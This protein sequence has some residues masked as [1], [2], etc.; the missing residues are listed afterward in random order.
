MNWI[1][2][3]ID[4]INSKYLYKF[5]SEENLK[6]FLDTGNIWFSRSDKF[7]DRMEC[8]MIKDLIKSPPD[9]K[10]IEARK[11]RH[12]ISCFHEGNIETLAFWDTYAK[13]DKDRRKYALRFNREDLIK[14]LILNKQAL[15][16]LSSISRLVH[17]RVRYL[18]LIGASNK[19]LESKTVSYTAFRKEYVFAYEREYRFD[20]TLKNETNNLGVNI[21]IGNPNDIDFVIHVNPLLESEDYIDCIKRIDQKG[22]K[23]KFEESTLAKWLKPELWK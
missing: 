5:L 16:S 23:I 1:S 7:G 11:R 4:D 6:K 17:G 3:N 10:E 20:I 19:K 9:F 2:Y 8:V 13:T 18:N 21:N 12:L 22:F 14:M 15:T